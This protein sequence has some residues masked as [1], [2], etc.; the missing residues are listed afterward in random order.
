M[1]DSNYAISRREYYADFV[2]APLAALIAFAWLVHGTVLL[3]PFLSA[4]IFGGL[5]WSLAEYLIHRFVFHG[6]EPYKHQH[7]LH[8]IAPP[9]FVGVSPLATV[10]LFVLFGFGL[11]M[12]FGRSIG[13]GLFIG[14]LGWYYAYIVLHDAYHHVAEF[15]DGS[16]LAILNA[17]HEYHHCRP[18][19]N[20]GVSS[21]LWDFVFSTYARPVPLARQR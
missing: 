14:L 3:V 19:V 10:A 18:R 17:N 8:H 21:P 15:R 9:D 20:F 12:I 2:T 1:D 13:V 11:P 16:L 7:H 4:I 5:T 6:V